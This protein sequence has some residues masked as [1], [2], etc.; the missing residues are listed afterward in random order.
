MSTAYQ[1]ILSIACKSD[2]NRSDKDIEE[3]KSWLRKTSDVFKNQKEEIVEVVA[4]KSCYVSRNLDDVVIRQGEVGDIVYIVL[5]GKLSVYVRP[6]A[7]GIDDARCAEL[8]RRVEADC[9]Q[10]R[11]PLDRKVFGNAVVTLGRG[12]MFGEV[13]L[14]SENSIR[15]ASVMC[16]EKCDLLAIDRQTYNQSLRSWQEEEFKEKTEFVKEHSLFRNCSL[17]NRVNMAISLRKVVIPYAGSICRQGEP[18][19]TAYFVSKGECR[20]VMTPKNHNSQFHNTSYNIKH[21]KIPEAYVGESTTGL[22]RP[23]S[24]FNKLRVNTE[25][26]DDFEVGISCADTIIG[27]VELVLELSSYIE[28]VV[29]N[30]HCVLFSLDKRNF[31]RLI[32][33]KMIQTFGQIRQAAELKVQRRLDRIPSQVTDLLKHWHDRLVAMSPEVKTSKKKLAF[34]RKVEPKQNDLKAL[35]RIKRHERLLHRGPIIQMDR[36]KPRKPRKK[37]IEEKEEHIPSTTQ[38]VRSRKRT[39]SEDE[40]MISASVFRSKR[41]SQNQDK[42]KIFITQRDESDDNDE[43]DEDEDNENKNDN[44]DG[45]EKY[46]LTCFRNHEASQKAMTALEDKLGRWY[47]KVGNLVK[48]DSTYRKASRV[49]SLSR[50]KERSPNDEPLKHGMVIIMRPHSPVFPNAQRAV[51]AHQHQVYRPI[52]W[53]LEEDNVNEIRFFRVQSAPARRGADGSA[54]SRP[55]SAICW[56]K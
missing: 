8:L 44:S 33:K 7:S 17:D 26:S 50:V 5:R 40:R 43:D 36:M 14:L 28:S 4:K 37:I 56:D 19:N 2:G 1:R 13:A 53:G 55:K 21:S 32:A 45:F 41:R 6:Q 22:R 49:R 39:D 31:E 38:V 23:K 25:E 30:T 34:Q 46:E 29:A 9:S 18:A 42:E 51:S 16:D 20:I 35:M 27:D 3:L 47:D 24:A 48:D 10:K 52:E 15:T 11:V 54:K 12:S